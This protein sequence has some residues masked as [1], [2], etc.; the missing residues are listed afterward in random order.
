[1]WLIKKTKV[2]HLLNT[3]YTK[4]NHMNEVIVNVFKSPNRQLKSPGYPCSACPGTGALDVLTSASGLGAGVAATV[5]MSSAVCC[6]NAAGLYTVNLSA[7]VSMRSASSFSFNFWILFSSFCLSEMH[8]EITLLQQKYLTQCQFNSLPL[9]CLLTIYVHAT[10]QNKTVF[11]YIWDEVSK[12]GIPRS[13][14][15]CFFCSSFVFTKAW[16]SAIP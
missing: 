10:T 7:H 16:L 11:E 14:S 8:H 5:A 4:I 15:H 1:M 6:G 9:T 2:A 3:S 13:S 12:V